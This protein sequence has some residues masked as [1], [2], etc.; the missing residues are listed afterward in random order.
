M[1]NFYKNIISPKDSRLGDLFI[2]YTTA[3]YGVFFL[4]LFLSYIPM[5]RS[6]GLK[7]VILLMAVVWFGDTGAFIIGR[8]YGQIKLSPNLSPNKTVEGAL[9]GLTFSFLACLICKFS[10]FNT[11]D[12]IDCL[13]ISIIGGIFGQI[14]DLTESFIKRSCNEKDSGKVMPGHGGIFDRFDGLIFAAPFFYFY[15]RMFF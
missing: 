10:F 12:L 3:I 13:N 1:T 9:G 8:K 15:A 7:W 4:T 6:S 14:G 11:L 5:L 2:D